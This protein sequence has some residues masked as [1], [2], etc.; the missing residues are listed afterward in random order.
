M[1]L[2]TET[3]KLLPI[4]KEVLDSKI[5]LDNLT[6]YYVESYTF[7]KSV[8]IEQFKVVVSGDPTSILIYTTASVAVAYLLVLILD[9]LFFKKRDKKWLR[10]VINL[11]WLILGPL[12]LIIA[13]GLNATVAVVGG[14]SEFDG[15]IEPLSYNQTF[16]SKLEY[17]NDKIKASLYPC[18]Y[19]GMV[20]S[21]RWYHHE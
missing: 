6:A 19:G 5:Y 12:S 18:L 20:Y 13:I 14:M 21:H 15:L 2:T 4:Y 9:V 8:F 7:I 11:F 1:S 16:F 10:I 3:I 17:P